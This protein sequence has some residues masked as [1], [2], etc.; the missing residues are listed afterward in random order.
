LDPDE[1]KDDLAQDMI[2]VLTSFCVPACTVGDRLT[3]GPGKRWRLSND[4][5]KRA[6]RYELDPYCEQHVLLAKYAGG[7]RFA[8]N[9]GLARR[10][11][12]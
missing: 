3:T 7:A 6:H 1:I 8:Y 10:S 11:E 5:V 4:K 12:T 9:W 2:E